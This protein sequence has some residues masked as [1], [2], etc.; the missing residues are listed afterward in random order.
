MKQHQS[1][2]P[3]LVIGLNHHSEKAFRQIFGLLGDKVY[4]YCRK[5]VHD[6]QEA[7]DLLQDIFCK[8]WQFRSRIDSRENV[9]VLLFTIARNH[10]LNHIRKKANAPV[11][12]PDNPLLLQHALAEDPHSLEFREMLLQYRQV[13]EKLGART[14]Q[15]FEL[16]REYD[17][18]NREIAE[19][20]LI[21]TKAVEF[22]ITKALKIIRSQL[23]A[24]KS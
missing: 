12:V 4:N 18:T 14:R 15:V 16:S 17:F 3:E 9:E 19:R 11:Q 22:H 13:I 21:S 1:V 10:L 6:P 2:D 5:V 8:L 7:E 24:I 20:L 23:K